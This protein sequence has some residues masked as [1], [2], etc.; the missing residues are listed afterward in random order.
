MDRN[1]VKHVTEVESSPGQ[2]A[3]LLEL[4][5]GA[6]QIVWH[7]PGVCR[8]SAANRKS[9]EDSAATLARMMLWRRRQKRGEAPRTGCEHVFWA[10]VAVD[11]G[12]V[13][14]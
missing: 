8:L 5:H 1:R 7:H 11:S 9:G 4:W 6:S 2:G 3:G 14:R 13:A 12:V 10:V